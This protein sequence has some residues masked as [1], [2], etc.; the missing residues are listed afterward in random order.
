[1]NDTRPAVVELAHS[2]WRIS[3]PILDIPAVCTYV[4]AV[5][6]ASS[7]LLIDAGWASELSWRTLVV[8]L[9]AI[10]SSISDVAGVFATH[11]H[12]DHAGL[13]GRVRE[14]S[15]AWI[16]MHEKDAFTVDWLHGFDDTDGL[17][18]WEIAGYRSAGV[19]EDDLSAMTE[20]GPMHGVVPP[21]RP[22]RRLTDGE[23]IT[24]AGR[25]FT[26]LWSP[27]HTPGHSGLYDAEAGRLFS[28]DHILSPVTP[29]VGIWDYPIVDEDP[30]GEYLASL[31]AIAK[32]PLAELLPAHER[33][34]DDVAGRVAEIKSHHQRRLDD[35]ERV[36][37]GGPRTLWQLTQEC[38]WEAPWPDM[39]PMSRRLALAELAAHV[40]RLE[41][42]GIAEVNSDLPSPRYGVKTT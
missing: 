31:D 42:C 21:A 2:T 39:S 22:D 1:M 15:G 29:H 35:V 41:R 23:F 32:M 10:G 19:A 37:R 27:G 26:V 17:R 36:L 24:V 9:E 13:A 6:C 18:D 7:V 25:R 16:G 34:I 14:A 38:R 3:I 5:R 20:Q 4:Y 11:H 30:L 12:P 40:R 33:P 8:G 28:G